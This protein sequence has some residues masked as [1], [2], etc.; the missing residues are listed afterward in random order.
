[1]SD[2]TRTSRLYKQVHIT[3]PH[4]NNVNNTIKKSF[5]SHELF[6]I[7]NR[8]LRFVVVEFV[9]VVHIWFNLILSRNTVGAL[10]T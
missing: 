10:V 3:N 6:I 9:H 5:V 1:M 2:Y 4:F 7:I 8:R